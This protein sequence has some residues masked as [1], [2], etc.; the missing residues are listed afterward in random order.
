MRDE[1]NFTAELGMIFFLI[2]ACVWMAAGGCGC[3]YDPISNTSTW[4]E[5]QSQTNRVGTSQP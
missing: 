5:Q 2:V 3:A 4:R 1:E